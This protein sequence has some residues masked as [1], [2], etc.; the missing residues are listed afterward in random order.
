MS[1]VI[2]G[3][4]L[5]MVHHSTNREACVEQRACKSRLEPVH[6]P[7]YGLTILRGLLYFCAGMVSSSRHRNRGETD[8]NTQPRALLISV[9][10]PLHESQGGLPHSFR[11]LNGSG[12]LKC[13][14]LV[15]WRR[16]FLQAVWTK[17]NGWDQKETSIVQRLVFAS[18]AW[19]C[20]APSTSF[21]LLGCD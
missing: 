1:S 11:G 4:H 12:G 14:F 2:Y 17:W 9:V 20:N 19:R 6:P 21:T 3:F 7:L 5:S 16:I 8:S 10:V 15:F 13:D 18:C